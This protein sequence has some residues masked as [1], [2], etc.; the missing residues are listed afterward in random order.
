MFKGNTELKSSIC[1]E[2]NKLS[3]DDPNTHQQ[4]NNLSEKLNELSEKWKKAAPIEK[5]DL[6][7]SWKEFREA[8]IDLFSFEKR[9]TILVK[10]K[11]RM[12][13]YFLKKINK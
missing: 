4:W 5:S 7:K 1:K 12:Q 10:G 13:T 2:I 11:G 8:T 3:E 6:K 9:E